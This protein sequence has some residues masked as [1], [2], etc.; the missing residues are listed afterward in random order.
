MQ[1]KIPRM[2]SVRTSNNLTK[3]REDS[4]HR[5]RITCYLWFSIAT[6]ASFIFCNASS[7]EYSTKMPSGIWITDPVV[8][9]F[10]FP[11]CAADS[12]NKAERNL[13]EKG[14]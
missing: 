13:L 5:Q 10:N 3:E 4:F 2:A 6:M 1:T 14:P 11:P 8:H 9:R 12:G 7:K